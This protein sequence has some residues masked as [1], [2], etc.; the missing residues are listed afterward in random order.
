[1]TSWEDTGK[2]RKRHLNRIIGFAV[3]MAVCIAFASLLPFA[4]GKVRAAEDAK[5]VCFME[6]LKGEDVDH[7]KGRVTI[8]NCNDGDVVTAV[9]LLQNED[10]SFSA[11]SEGI[12]LVSYNAARFQLTL[13]IA[14]KANN[15]NGSYTFSITG[16]DIE[17]YMVGKTVRLQGTSVKNVKPGD[18]GPG[19]GGPGAGGP[20][21][22]K[23]GGPGEENKP[24]GPGENKPGGPGEGNKPAG[25]GEENKP[26]ENKPGENNQGQ[27]NQGQYNQGQDNQGQNNQGQNNQGQ[28]ETTA[29]TET[30]VTTT[31]ATTQSTTAAET[32]PAETSQPAESTTATAT[33]APSVTTTVPETS[34]ETTVSE[35]TATSPA[36]D[37]PTVV[38]PGEVEPSVDKTE[39]SDGILSETTV[40][41]TTTDTITIGAQPEK[42]SSSKPSFIWWLLL[43][44]LLI[45]IYLRYRHLKKKDMSF[46]EICKNFIP[47]GALVSKIKNAGKSDDTVLDGPQPEVMNGYLQKP[48]VGLAAAQA[49]RPVRS[50]VSQSASSAKAPV[51]KPEAAKPDAKTEE[52]KKDAGKAATVSRPPVKRSSFKTEDPELRAMEKKQAELER[53][54]KDLSSYKETLPG[55]DDVV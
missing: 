25:P 12:K 43:L 33:E 9:F 26:G 48:T 22:N 31:V 49:I 42:T 34:E 36:E 10:L 32:K 16:S 46:P 11:F 7:V 23:P 2:M 20:G 50:N 39:P 6:C 14:G 35:E 54:L 30:T 19:A 44:L 45:V 52:V 3:I 17:G 28:T 41:E 51:K 47:V 24:G 4:S 55:E 5:L 27:N 53:K 15:P 13:E 18:E 40:A 8:K 29:Q 21:E 37:T 1:M 38:A